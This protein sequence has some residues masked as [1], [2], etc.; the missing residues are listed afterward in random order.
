MMGQITQTVGC[1]HP[2]VR[3]RTGQCTA[4]TRFCTVFQV[5]QE[6]EQKH[7][8]LLWKDNITSD[9]SG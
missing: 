4:F 1:I 8:V 3:G 7:Y 5:G 9:G 6:S 2:Q